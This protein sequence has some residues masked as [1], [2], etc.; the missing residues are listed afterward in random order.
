MVGKVQS[1]FLM[2]DKWEFGYQIVN[3]SFLSLPTLQATGLL[4]FY[5]ESSISV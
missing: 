2:Q 3:A 1:G 4:E 5:V